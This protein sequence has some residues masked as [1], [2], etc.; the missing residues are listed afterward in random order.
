MERVINA[1]LL[2]QLIVSI[3]YMIIGVLNGIESI[4]QNSEPID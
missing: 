3:G 1:E 2:R 4:I